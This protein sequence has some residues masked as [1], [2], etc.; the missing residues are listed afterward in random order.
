M[1]SSHDYT[2]CNELDYCVISENRRIQVNHLINTRY[3]GRHDTKRGKF[4]EIIIQS[5]NAAYWLW[6]TLIS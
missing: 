1:N 3:S 2:R 6:L 4:I 5:S